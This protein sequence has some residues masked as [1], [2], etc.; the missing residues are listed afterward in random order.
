MKEE[1]SALMDGELEA[2]QAD[3]ALAHVARDPAARETWDTYHLIGDALR[4]E[5]HDLKAGATTR[6]HARLEAEPTVLAP[7][8]RARRFRWADARLATAVAA[9]LAVLSV[10]A[11]YSL[12]DAGDE[13]QE[14]Q[15]IAAADSDS[16]NEYLSAHEEF[17]PSSGYRFAALGR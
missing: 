3:S 8:P 6:L 16:L 12:H 7:K 14:A 15:L 11:W 2:A 13:S 4:G 10:V 9:S 1:V 17:A 5:I